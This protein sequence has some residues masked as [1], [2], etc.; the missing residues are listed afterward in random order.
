[1]GSRSQIWAV[2]RP[3]LESGDCGTDDKLFTYVNASQD[4][5]DICR[6]YKMATARNFTCGHTAT[7][8]VPRSRQCVQRSRHSVISRLFT[9]ARFDSLSSC[10]HS[11]LHAKPHTTHKACPGM[12]ASSKAPQRCPWWTR[13][14]PSPH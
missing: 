3:G 10:T 11:E 6:P 7:Q 8:A 9:G 5:R 12:Q 1:M 4:L 14:T 2:T 13:R